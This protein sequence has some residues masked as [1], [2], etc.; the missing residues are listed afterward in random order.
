MKTLLISLMFLITLGGFSAAKA[1]QAGALDPN[2]GAGGKV[3]TDF[4]GDFDRVFA[5]A[6]QTDGK[7]I[8]G[9][10]ARTANLTTD[11]A[12]ARYNSD[13][14]LDT[15]F[16]GDGKATTDFA[17]SG[18]NVYA[19]LIQPDGKIIA[20]GSARIGTTTNFA[21]A[22]YLPNGALDTSFDADGKVNTDFRGDFDQIESLALQA[23][24]KIVAAGVADDANGADDF[25]LARYN[26]N[27]SLDAS[28]DG[29]G[30]IITDFNQDTDWA[31]AVAIQTDGKIIAGGKT[32]TATSDDFALARYNSN[33]ILDTTF[34]ADGLATTDFLNDVD[35]I[36]TILIQPDGKIVATG[37]ASLFNG[38]Q[39]DFG[40][41]R[42]N[43]DGSLDTTFSRDGRASADF[44]EDFDEGF[45]AVL[46]ADGKIVV[47]GGARPPQMGSTVNFGLARF[48]S[49]G[50]AD[51]TFDG[52]G[53]VLTHFNGLD[54]INALALQADGKLVAAGSTIGTNIADF[55]LARYLN[56][57][58][59][60]GKQIFDFDGDG[61]TDISIFRPSAGEW[62]YLRSS[63]GQNRAFS[64]GTSTD[65]LTPADFTGDGK[66]DIAFFR[67]ATGEWFVLR[68]EDNSFYSYP[69]GADGD[70]PFAGDFDADLKADSGVFRPST[71]TW[72]IRKSSD[73]TAIIQQFGQTGDV[74]VVADYDGDGKADIAIY[75]A[76]SGQWW[77]NRSTLGGVAFQFGNSTDKPVVGD[78][79]GDGKADVAFF[80]PSTS[81]WFVLRS[82]NQSFYSFPFGAAGDIPAAGDY[83][84]D[85]EFDAAVFRP[86][87]ATWFVQR[88]NAG[89]LIQNF[90][91]NGDK[92]LPS[93]F[94]P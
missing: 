10:S 58:A 48:N 26:T 5:I 75:R 18:D 25:G 87:S 39:I 90:G 37:I 65:K 62:W 33:G 83:D 80:R 14:S 82:E 78:Y 32:Q 28:F 81:E 6:I 41:A 24:G 49:D 47:G 60:G 91:Q 79:T 71:A 31:F 51:T 93:S 52:D 54:Q 64:F 88:T 94:I 85:G 42:Y 29:D 57:P 55:A 34:D 67:P 74:P 20:G 12:L 61:K 92:P 16:D 8:V 69:F 46:Q 72:F 38:T 17:S 1:Q 35:E 2:F 89:T 13:G 11:F 56:N 21:L 30:K 27:G 15:S 86:S 22:R 43:A 4:F 66:T 84:G 73:G 50:T 76:T 77:I 7:I 23:D 59:T 70:V 19:L 45:A 63:D 36:N 9:G 68:S 44:G 3:T 40:A 53:K